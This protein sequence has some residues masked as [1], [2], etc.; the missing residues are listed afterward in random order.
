MVSGVVGALLTPLLVVDC[1]GVDCSKMLDS[2]SSSSYIERSSGKQNWPGRGLWGCGRQNGSYGSSQN[3]DLAPGVFPSVLFFVVGDIS[4][5]E[6]PV[7]DM[8]D[9]VLVEASGLENG[10]GDTSAKTLP[11]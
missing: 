7:S 8:V 4:S 11:L 5:C 3:T 6:E 1:K 2:S 9:G 10:R